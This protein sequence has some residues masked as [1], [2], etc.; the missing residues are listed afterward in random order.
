MK[1]KNK[2]IQLSIPYIDFKEKKLVLDSIEKNEISTFV[3]NVALFEKNISKLTGA[4]Y[5]LAVNSGSS[6]LLLA[7]KSIN[8]KTSKEIVSKNIEFNISNFYMTDSISR[9]SETMAKCTK[10]ILNKVV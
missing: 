10:E 5:N 3:R 1:Q 4:K 9:A 7:F 6:A 8:L 2:K